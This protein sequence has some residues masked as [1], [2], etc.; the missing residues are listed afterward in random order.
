MKESESK[1]LHTGENVATLLERKGV[2]K[3]K[4]Q[5]ARAIFKICF[6]IALNFSILFHI[7]Q[8]GKNTLPPSSPSPHCNMSNLTI[9]WCQKN[10]FTKRRAVVERSVVLKKKKKK[11]GSITLYIVL[12]FRVNY[13]FLSLFFFYK[14]KKYN[15]K[16]VPRKESELTPVSPK[17]LCPSILYNTTRLL[18]ARGKQHW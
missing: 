2:L 9:S 11:P 8:N 12:P 3:R 15:R 6:K 1:P 14:K 7:C 4:S 5:R 17:S 10:H 16:A 13:T 18:G